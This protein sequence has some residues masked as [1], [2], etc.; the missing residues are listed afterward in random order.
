MIRKDLASA[1]TVAGIYLVRCRD[2][3]TARDDDPV[4][5]GPL[6]GATREQQEFARSRARWWALRG[7]GRTDVE[8]VQVV[9]IDPDDTGETA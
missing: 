2:R 7:G 4:I 1:S 6:A 9:A 3:Q 5:E 8:M